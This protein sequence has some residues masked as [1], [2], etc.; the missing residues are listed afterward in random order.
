MWQHGWNV[1]CESLYKYILRGMKKEEIHFGDINRW[2]YGQAPPEFMIEVFIRTI[3]ILVFLLLVVRL[4]GSRMA[5]QITITELAVM[6]TLGGIV[7][8]SMQL[9]DRGLLFGIVA[10]I[11]A[12]I[13]QRGINL[14]A[15]KNE[16][17]EKLTQGHMSV[18]VRDGV[19][20]IDELRRNRITRQQLYAML[21]KK[22]I[23][24]L[25]KIDRVYLEACGALS[26][27]EGDNSKAGLPISP[28]KDPEILKLQKGVDSG[29][30]ACCRCGHVQRVKEGQPACEVCNE[31]EWAEAYSLSTQKAEHEA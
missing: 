7:S 20:D 4:M 27:F 11:C 14:W 22:D 3:L 10:L 28:G 9:P 5:G 26:V 24:N 21:R 2:L 30:M 15:F 17:I 31:K 29:M 13:F 25:G 16:K 23:H 6:I 8:P 18:L 12:L 1:L 19:L